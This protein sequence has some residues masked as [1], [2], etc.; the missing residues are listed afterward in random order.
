MFAWQAGAHH[1]QDAHVRIMDE[2]G[3]KQGQPSAQAEGERG[4]SSRLVGVGQVVQI[5]T[6]ASTAMF[7]HVPVHGQ[8]VVQ[9]LLLQMMAHT[10]QRSYEDL[11]TH[12]SN[13]WP[14]CRGK[15]FAGSLKQ[16]VA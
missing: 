7:W 10:C 16:V 4:R 1:G 12:A 3:S 13:L 14:A 6:C 2:G 9:A 15:V 11:W 8:V 5:N